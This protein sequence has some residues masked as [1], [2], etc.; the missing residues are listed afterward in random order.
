M[1]KTSRKEGG[2]S[3]T[4]TARPVGTSSS[5]EIVIDASSGI[6]EDEQR[7]ILVQINGIAEKNRRSLASGMADGG[8]ETGDGSKRRYKAQKNGGLFPI[9]VNLFA[10]AALAG[11]FFG[12]YTLQSGVEIDAR[13][14]TRVFNTGER[15]L[16]E[17]IRRETG[18]LLSA[19][20]M[21]INSILAS[22]ADLERQLHELLA[23]SEVLTQEQ[24]TIQNQLLAQQDERRSAL[25]QAREE[26]SRILAEARSR[27]AVLQA[28]LDARTREL[29]AVS[30]RHA[31]ELDAA[32]AELSQLSMDQMQAAAI[33][34][35]LAG[36][37]ANVNRHV[38]ASRFDE[39]EEAIGSLWDVL[40]LPAFQGIRTIQARRDLYTQA[41]GSL[42][43][44]LEEARTAHAAMVAGALP[45]DRAAESRLLE[46]IARLEEELTA[47]DDR[48][49]DLMAGDVGAAQ[50]ISQLQSSNTQLESSVAS[51]RTTNANLTTQNTSLT[52]QVTGLNTQVTGLQGNLTTER[53]AA[54]TLRQ[55]VSSLQGTNTNLTTQN[56][57]LNQT[58]AARDGTIRDLEGERDRARTHSQSAME[59]IVAEVENLQNVPIT[60]IGPALQELQRVVQSLREQM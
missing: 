32:R 37:F 7:E 20:D 8:T 3:M 13:E 28:Q 30:A 26:R 52:T 41:A 35:Q 24:I 2:T 57:T 46:E 27:E 60:Q 50:V 43:I 4:S 31:V 23:G 6:S 45:P 40:N 10:L 5:A 29:A 16:I 14:G 12:L 36:L 51:L 56:T 44:L 19:K 49:V 34:A 58:V 15:A 22:L 33:E 47:R 17:E 18:A 59:V 11:G 21:E 48:I 1:A 38:S 53:Q 9:L 54:E 25:A 55:Q 42:E 39:A